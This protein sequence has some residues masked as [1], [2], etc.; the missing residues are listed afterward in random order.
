MIL[1]HSDEIRAQVNEKMRDGKGSVTVRY[2]LEPEEMFG[3]GRLFAEN[4]V[5]VGASIGLHQHK[6]DSEAY[7][8]LRGSGRYLNNSDEFA[9]EA[10]DVTVVAEGDSHSIENTGDVPLVFIA[11]ILF[12]EPKT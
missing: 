8:Y 9:V 11:L 1:R 7:Y 6:G 3:K 4:I 5:P 12:T 10:G 2:L